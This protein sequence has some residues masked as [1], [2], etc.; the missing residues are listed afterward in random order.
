MVKRHF[1]LQKLETAWKRRSVLWLSGVRRVGKTFDLD[2]IKD[3]SSSNA[4]SPS[5]ENDEKL[6]GSTIFNPRFPT[7]SRLPRLFRLAAWLGAN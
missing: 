2:E 3:L 7:F 6:A 4:E 1:W 5:F